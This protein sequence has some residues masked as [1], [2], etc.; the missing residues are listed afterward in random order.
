MSSESPASPA[1][2]GMIRDLIAFNTVSRNSNLDLIDFVRTYLDGHGVSSETITSPDGKKANLFATIGPA[3]R[4][5]VIVSGHTDVVPVD[6]EEWTGDPFVAEVRKGRLYGRGTA[7]MKGFV[8][9]ALAHVPHFLSCDLR[10]PIHLAL[11]YDEEVGCVGVRGLIDWLN[12]QPVKPALC[13][14]GEPTGMTLVNGHKGNMRKRCH[15][16]GHEG[17]SSQAPCGVNAIE[18]AA[19]LIAHIKAVIRRFETEG[20]RDEAYDVPFTTG[21][22]GRIEGGTALNII[23]GDCTFEIEFRHISEDD[24]D[25]IFSGIKAHAADHLEPMMQA[26]DAGSGFHWQDI[27]DTPGFDIAPDSAAVRLVGEWAQTEKC[28]KVAFGTEGGLFVKKGGIPAVVCGPG[29]IA[30]AH[31]PDEYIELDQLRRCESFMHRLFERACA[32]PLDA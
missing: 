2:I 6:G 25:A 9:I 11:S 21:N 19:E 17:H 24:P 8:G 32:G 28:G 30:Q 27:S 15:V 23:A 4:P 1:S 29:S 7:D 3:D 22:V 14:V 16:R 26:V 31:K 12:D 10:F 13:V 20:A 5:G 18:Y